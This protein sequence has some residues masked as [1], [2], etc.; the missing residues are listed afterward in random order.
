MELERDDGTRV[1]YA[2][3]GPPQKF[4]SDAD[5]E[6]FCAD[7][8]KRASLQLDEVRRANGIVYIHCLQ[9][10]QYLPGSKPMERAEKLQTI[11]GGHP[12]QRFVEEGYPRLQSRG[13]ELRAAGERFYDLTGIFADHPEATYRDTCCHMNQHGYELIG[14]RIGAIVRAELET[15]PSE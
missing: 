13:T 10:N 9:P 11:A 5:L 15:Q 6:G 2:V 12:G 4:E 14:S 1:S 8:W 7:L 3:S